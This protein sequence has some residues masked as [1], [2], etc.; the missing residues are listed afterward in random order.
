MSL[1]QLMVAAAGIRSRV[2]TFG[3]TGASAAAPQP[4]SAPACGLVRELQL[5]SLFCFGSGEVAFWGNF[6]EHKL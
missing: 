1:S 5:G 2:S 3:N 4:R 6:C